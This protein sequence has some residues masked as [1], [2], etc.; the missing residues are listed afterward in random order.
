MEKVDTACPFCGQY[1]LLMNCDED[2]WY[3]LCL[4]CRASGPCS[5]DR[6]EALQ[7]WIDR[8][9]IGDIPE[10]GAKRTIAFS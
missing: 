2:V 6:M 1:D 7:A 8:P 4:T 9:E 3:C 10:Y 5:D